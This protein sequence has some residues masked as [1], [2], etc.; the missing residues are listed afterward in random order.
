DH[1]FP[2]GHRC[3]DNDARRL[4]TACR[5]CNTSRRHTSV[6][7]WL[8]VLRGLGHD[9]VPILRRLAIARYVP[10][11]RRAGARARQEERDILLRPLPPLDPD[12]VGV[13]NGAIY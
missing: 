5:T 12:A 2:R 6:A 9:L 13:A 11:N 3:R 8:R 7:S 4:V 10:I 1:L